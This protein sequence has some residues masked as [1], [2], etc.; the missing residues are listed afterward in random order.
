[1]RRQAPGLLCL[2]VIE[3]NIGV[4]SCDRLAQGDVAFVAGD[5]ADPVAL[6]LK[7]QPRLERLDVCLIQIHELRVALVRLKI[8][9]HAVM[10][11]AAEQSTSF[12][13][14]REI[15]N[16]AVLLSQIDVVKLIASLVAPIKDAV[17]FREKRHRKDVVLGRVRKL[18]RFAAGDRDGIG[19]EQT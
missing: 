2:R 13:P 11:P 12:L 1:M 15:L 4:A 19:V 14:R 17:V 9:T 8:E 18:R 6:V 16:R 3:K 7:Q 5:R 10:G